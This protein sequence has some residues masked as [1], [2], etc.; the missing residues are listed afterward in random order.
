MEPEEYFNFQHSV[1]KKRYDAFKRPEKW[2]FFCLKGKLFFKE[3][4]GKLKKNKRKFVYLSNYYPDKNM[5]IFN[6]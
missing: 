3:N 6:I 2:I 1:N 4:K 5:K